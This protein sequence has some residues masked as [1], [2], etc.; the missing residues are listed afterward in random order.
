M[1]TGRNFDEILAV[2]DPCSSPSKHKSWQ[3]PPIGKNGD[4]VI[5]VTSVTDDEANRCS[6]PAGKAVRTVFAGGEAA[7]LIS[8]QHT[9]KVERAYSGS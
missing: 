3:H 5:I 2:L 1:T 4:E 6:L 8:R 7:N 9:C